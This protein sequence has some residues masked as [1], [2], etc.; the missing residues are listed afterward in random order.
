MNEQ[1]N[2]ITLNFADG[3][4][5]MF[6]VPRGANILDAAIAAEMPVLYQCRSG[7]CSLYL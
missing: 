1:L 6:S 7:G 2:Q 4:T 5:H 3:V